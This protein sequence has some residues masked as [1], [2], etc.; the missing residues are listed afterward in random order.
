MNTCGLLQDTICRR[1]RATLARALH[2]ADTRIGRL[3]RSRVRV[4]FEA[5]SPLSLAIFRPV[6]DR[7]RGDDRL[8]FWYTTSDPAWEA[9]QIFAPAGL[10]ERVVPARR[11]RWMQ[12]D[13][14][15]N[16]DFWNMTWAPRAA[17]RVH[18]FHGVAGKY[19]LDAP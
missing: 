9:A 14:Y 2:D 12:F 1:A 6:L 16:T 17:R 18:L 3:M 7:L 10:T 15:I 8:E 19:G 13:A 11:A 4:L 5:A